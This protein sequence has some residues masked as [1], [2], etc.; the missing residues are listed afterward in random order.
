MKKDY[1]SLFLRIITYIAIGITL[2]VVIAC[3]G[4]I[5]VRGLPNISWSLFA[6]V[7]TSE[8]VS[9]F[10][11]LLNTIFI[12]ILALVIAVPIGVFAAIYLVE[13]VSPSN[14]LVGAIR[15]ATETLSGVPSIV[16]GLFGLL[17]FVTKLQFGYSILAGG[18]TLA[19]MILPTI[20]RTT[21]E[22]LLSVRRSVREGSFALGAG[23]LR[24]IFVV[25]LP[26]AL[27]TIFSGTMLS[28]GRIV[29]ETAAVIYTAGT[30]AKVA[31]NFSASGR[32]LAVH[33]YNLSSEGLYM[34]QAQA[35]ALVL[36]VLVVLL[37]T[38]SSLLENKL[39]KIK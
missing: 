6:P 4:F 5:V 19:L 1:V 30:V 39:G 31:T 22:A 15:L 36:L 17:F 10:P 35:T 25:V 37:N 23:K 16:Y 18:C 33:M 13:Y 9:L 29:G 11:A 26:V 38:G 12:T 3:I 8:N 27:P 2:S 24:T 34:E 32:T 14:K 7:Y 28:I 20:M 21:E